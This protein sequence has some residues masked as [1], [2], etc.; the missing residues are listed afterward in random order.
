[1]SSENAF[2]N[3]FEESFIVNEVFNRGRYYTCFS[4]SVFGF[5]NGVRK[6]HILS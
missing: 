1:M 5:G 6:R 2:S 4:D 3:T